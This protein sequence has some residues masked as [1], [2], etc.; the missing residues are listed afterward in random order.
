M[1][2]LPKRVGCAAASRLNFRF[3]MSDDRR[4]FRPQPSR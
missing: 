1:S 3:G 4:N 2:E